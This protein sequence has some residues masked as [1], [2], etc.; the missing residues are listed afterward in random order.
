MD[1]RLKQLDTVHMDIV[2]G[3]QLRCIGCP[4]STLLDQVGKIQVEDFARQMEN[5]DVPKIGV[6]RLFN[7]G[8]PLIHHDLPGILSAV[9]RSGKEISVVEI[10]TNA[11]FARW[12]QLERAIAMKVIHRLVVSCDGDGTPQS[13][14]RLRP[15]AKWHK[16]VTF[17]ERVSRLRQAL[18]PSLELVTRTV[19]CG[20]AAIETWHRML[21]PLGWRPEFRAW[22]ILPDA[23]ENP[24]GRPFI[25]G[26][27]LCK[28]VEG[29]A[30]L[31]VDADGTVVPC[32]V[33][34]RAGLLGNLRE[35]KLSEILAGA[36]RQAFVED[37]RSRRASMPVC[38][39]CEF[40]PESNPGAS[41][42][43]R[44]EFI[45]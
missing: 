33:H 6:L 25:A 8:E 36:Q 11:Q 34:P 15:P 28:F 13:Y 40:G 16:L 22:K 42:G 32:C 29:T 7:Y 3:C 37:L 18:D 35:H 27:G 20:R 26:Q 38:S 10:S 1:E 41:A 39:R 30:Q 14:E 45:P 19:I 4:N 9:A 12:T 43:D 17:L 21:D 5:I 44:L 23:A 31:Y 24:S 2:H